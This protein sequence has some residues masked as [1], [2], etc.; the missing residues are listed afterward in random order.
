M[1][2]SVIVVEI[3]CTIVV[4]TFLVFGLLFISPLTFISSYPPEIQEQYYESQNKQ[5]EKEKITKIMIIKKIV[6]V[7]LMVYV[8]AWML[9]KAGIETFGDG[10][11]LSYLFIFIVFAWDTFFLDWVLF[12]NIKKIRLPGTEYMDKEYHQKWFHVK[13]CIPMIP[14]FI[15]MGIISSLVMIWLW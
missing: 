2:T 13:A 15:I 4:F 12:A 1:N 3:I 14:V 11:R 6:A 9:H 8:L 10:L 5:A 7:I